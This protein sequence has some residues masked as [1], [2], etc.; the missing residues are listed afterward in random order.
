MKI[1]PFGTAVQEQIETFEQRF[2]IALPDDF[3]TFVLTCNGAVLAGEEVVVPELSVEVYPEILF[4]FLAERGLNLVTFNTEY[5]RDLA[6]DTILIG[7]DSISNFILLET[8]SED[9]GVYYYDHRHYFPKSS[10]KQNTFLMADN[11]TEFLKTQEG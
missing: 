4:G 11:F 2:K 8:S 7:R 10:H 9:G 1:R 6:P 3:K 5:E